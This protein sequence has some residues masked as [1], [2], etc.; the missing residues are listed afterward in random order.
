[1]NNRVGDGYEWLHGSLE[2]GPFQLVIDIWRVSSDTKTCGS[3][4]TRRLAAV[5]FA[6]GQTR[7]Y[8]NIFMNNSQEG[9]AK[10]LVAGG[11]VN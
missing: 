10:G 5:T 1:M 9:K 11:V 7:G 4:L 8:F 6:G 3:P 2:I